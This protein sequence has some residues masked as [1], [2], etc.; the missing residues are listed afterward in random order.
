[1]PRYSPVY[2][3]QSPRFVGVRAGLQRQQMWYVVPYLVQAQLELGEVREAR[4]LALQVVRYARTKGEL[5]LLGIALLVHAMVA[6]RRGCWQEA[7]RALEEGLAIG[8]RW[9]SEAG[10]G[11]APFLEAYG[12][13]HAAKGEPERAR[14]KQESALAMFRRLGARRDIERVEQLLVSAACRA[15]QHGSTV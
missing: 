3:T 13:W 15:A 10:D 4:R 9:S 14:E 8:W 6:T 12:Q 1:M 2:A 5:G 11:G 7:E